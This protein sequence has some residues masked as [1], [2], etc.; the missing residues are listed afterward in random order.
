VN[1]DTHVDHG[2][3]HW[4]PVISRRSAVK[5]V[6]QGDAQRFSGDVASRD[7]G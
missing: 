2:S 6:I 3:R 4:A 7:G 5:V 1:G